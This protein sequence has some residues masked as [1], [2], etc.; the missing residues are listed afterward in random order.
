MQKWV[1]IILYILDY[2]WDGH[3]NAPC[4]KLQINILL[5]SVVMGHVATG[6][7]CFYWG[8]LPPGPGGCICLRSCSTKSGLAA[9]MC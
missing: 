6:T 9:C 3:N 8:A 5:F 7:L 4:K 2:F 1:L